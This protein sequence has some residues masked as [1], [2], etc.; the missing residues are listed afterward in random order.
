MNNK[1][2][3]MVLIISAAM[4]VAGCGAN[5]TDL[6]L[7]D[8]NTIESSANDNEMSVLDSSYEVSIESSRANES[9]NA[10]LSSENDIVSEYTVEENNNSAE[11]SSEASS[12]D[13]PDGTYSADD[14]KRMYSNY[15]QSES[16]V[17]DINEIEIDI[18]FDEG[19]Y[20]IET[21]KDNETDSLHPV[22]AGSA[23]IDPISGEG[24][25][26]TWGNYNDPDA[27][28]VDFSKYDY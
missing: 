9:S 5:N 1:K 25:F 14:I 16:K 27:I 7:S 3:F 13:E 6:D 17:I 22:K 15:V 2:S 18:F 23:Y 8:V 21:F 19:I 20:W 26:W 24:K 10:E 4:L 11:S 28:S 12:A